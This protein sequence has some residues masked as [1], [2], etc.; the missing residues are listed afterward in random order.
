[1]GFTATRLEHMASWCL[2]CRD[3]ASVRSDAWRQFFGE[4][5]D[6]GVK[7]P[8]G[9]GDHTSRQRRFLGWFLLS[10]RVADGRQPAQVAAA[11]LY[12]GADL[13]DAIEAVR[14]ARYVLAIVTTTDARRS[15]F[16]ELEDERFEVRSATWAQEI[17]RGSAVVAHLVPVRQRFWLPGPGWLEWPALIGPN[18]RRELKKLQPEPIQIER[19]LQGRSSRTETNASQD[20]PQDATLADAVARMSASAQAAGRTGLV[21]PLEDWQALVLGNLSSSDPNAFF[22]EVIGRAGAMASIDELNRW[23]G[24]ANNIWNATPQPDRGG[25]TANEL[26]QQWRRRLD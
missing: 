7:Y 5:D 9:V 17:P 3:L 22:G 23:L 21:L 10:F 14:R 26:M 18:M 12:H 4:D 13:A 19:V 2:N 15:S 25:K 11:A 1:M 24:L 20:Q 16:L 8:A 6:G